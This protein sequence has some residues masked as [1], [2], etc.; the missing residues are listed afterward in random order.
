MNCVT[1]DFEAN[2]LPSRGRSFPIEVGICGPLGTRSWLIRPLPEWRQW[3]WTDEAIA[4]HGITLQQL[5]EQGVD[6]AIVVA[7]VRRAVG[8]RRLVADSTID[9]DWWQTLLDAAEPAIPVA[10]HDAAPLVI[11][12]IS[13]VFDELC[14]TD[15]QIE[16]AQR[17]ANWLRADRH[18]AGADARWLYTLLSD[19]TQQIA[20][21]RP[22]SSDQPCSD[23]TSHEAYLRVMREPQ[24]AR[25]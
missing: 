5:D 15:E 24:T 17:R 2:C 4:L 10:P 21:E 9:Q 25:S 18:R 19:L 12:H 1:I 14:A 3:A 23:W 16:S 11:E 6:P 8:D 20:A 13:D 7:E 22:A